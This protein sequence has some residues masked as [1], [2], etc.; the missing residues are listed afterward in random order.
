MYY[1]TNAAADLYGVAQEKNESY[2]FFF[3]LE[4]FS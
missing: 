3:F 4:L 2:F 1:C